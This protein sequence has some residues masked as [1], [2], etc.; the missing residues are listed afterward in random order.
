ML[1]AQTAEI[2]LPDA[3]IMRAQKRIGKRER[4]DRANYQQNAARF[5]GIEKFP[6]GS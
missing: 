4:N 3:Q 1:D 2:H 6:E 5:F